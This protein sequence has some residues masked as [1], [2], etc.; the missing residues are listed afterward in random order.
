VHKVYDKAQTP[1]QQALA[2]GILTEAKQQELAAI[3][4]GLNPTLL[5]SWSEPL[6]LD[7]LG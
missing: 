6:K 7:T 5:L 4:D 2:A 1:Y 3:Y